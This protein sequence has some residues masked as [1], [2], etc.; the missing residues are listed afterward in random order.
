MSAV[1]IENFSYQ[2]WYHHQN[3]GA[4]YFRSQTVRLSHAEMTALSPFVRRLDFRLCCLR[5]PVE[6]RKDLRTTTP[7]LSFAI[8]REG[9]WR[10]GHC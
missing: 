7:A 5:L 1:P 6:R 4:P 2:R 8:G 9:E 3:F 10:R